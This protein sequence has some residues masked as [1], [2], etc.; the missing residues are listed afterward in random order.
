AMANQFLVDFSNS[1]LTDT[2]TILRNFTDDLPACES[3]KRAE[4]NEIASNRQ[5]YDIVS[6]TIGTPDVTLISKAPAR[7][8]PST[9]TPA[10]SS[11]SIG[12]QPRS[13]AA[14][15]STSG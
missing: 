8:I 2:A 11:R 10:R 9:E 4:A 1:S 14:C 3:A 15:R 7:F 6:S 5:N 12:D 13:R